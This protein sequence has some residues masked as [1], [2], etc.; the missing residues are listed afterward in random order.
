MDLIRPRHW[1]A[2]SSVAFLISCSSV[3][4]Q[5]SPVSEDHEIKIGEQV[6]TFELV[7]HEGKTVSLEG[8]TKEGSVAVVFYR[9][10]DW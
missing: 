1:A 10:A 4:A 6:P 9:S 8:L 3:W 2:L 7:S 5:H